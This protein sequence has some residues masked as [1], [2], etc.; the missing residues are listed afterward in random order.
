MI[1]GV[2]KEVKTDEYRVSLTP[3]KVDLLVKNGHTVLVEHEAGA[4]AAFSDED[5][6]AVRASIVGGP[7]E[8]FDRGGAGRQGQGAPASGVH[9]PSR[10]SD[11]F[12]IPT[13][14]TGARADTG[15]PERQ[16]YGNCLRD[17]AE[18]GR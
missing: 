14:G 17:R 16:G 7:E 18:G 5:Y 10:E 11:P 13:S 8:I 4:G 12:H 9:V 2:P 3:D 1:I 15:P 6:Q